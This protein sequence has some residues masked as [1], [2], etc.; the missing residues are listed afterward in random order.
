MGGDCQMESVSNRGRVEIV[1]SDDG[2][3]TM[4]SPDETPK[5]F[6]TAHYL[7]RSP[8]D[9]VAQLPPDFSLK[10]VCLTGRDGVRRFAPVGGVSVFIVP[11]SLGG[12]A[13]LTRDVNPGP[14]QRFSYHA[15][16]LVYQKAPHLREHLD[17][18]FSR[19][20]D[21]YVPVS[22]R[23][24]EDDRHVLPGDLGL[25]S[26][27]HGT[28]WAPTTLIEQGRAAATLAGTPNPDPAQCIRRGLIAAARL[29]PID[30]ATLSEA[31]ARGLV[32]LALFDLGPS[33]AP[34]DEA[35]VDQVQER[36]WA[37]L[38][39]HIGDD[40]E[41]FNQWF[42][43]NADN[44]VHA[45]AKQKKGGRP[46]SRETVRRVVLELVVRSFMYIG[47]LCPPSDDGVRQGAARPADCGGAG[48]LWH[49]LPEAKVL[50]WSAVRPPA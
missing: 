22:G 18:E 42:F 48:P 45:I 30:P 46:V 12:Y 7:W 3:S 31:E 49:A 25:T 1:P 14:E 10:L 19:E 13:L 9:I 32:R 44:I 17:R 26:T 21:L 34:I 28:P 24:S 20:A 40:T 41:P 37:A 36:L 11:A 16:R 50:G 43:T 35:V 47:G 29:N 8:P 39:R 4:A 15:T 23:T 27:G 2:P 5:P 38:E 6:H 33:A